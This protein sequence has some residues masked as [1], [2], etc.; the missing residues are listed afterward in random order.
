MKIGYHIG[1]SSAAELLNNIKESRATIES[2]GFE[3]CVQI[4]VS[5][6]RRFGAMMP[7]NKI[8]A[9]RELDIPIVVHGAYIDLPWKPGAARAISNIVKEYQICADIGAR[10]LVV[11]FSRAATV[12]ANAARALQR[13]EQ[14]ILAA[15][16]QTA[17]QTAGLDRGPILFLE[18]NS[19]KPEHCDF[20]HVHQLN[21]FFSNIRALELRIPVGLCIDTAHLWACGVSM[22]TA[23]DVQAWFGTLNVR[24]PLL[25]H[26]NDNKHEL[27]AGR[28]YHS[29]L[30]TNIW[31]DIHSGLMEIMQVAD[32]HGALFIVERH[33]E[34]INNES[35]L[36]LL[37]SLAA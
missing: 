36:A 17:G 6:P 16:G 22:K 24:A 27:A 4:F 19:A 25:L 14:D 20:A 32:R 3:S 29:P 9:I 26:L 34:D 10:G 12:P 18:I 31:A 11:H 8:A 7:E 5:N 23:A 2:Y 1:G 13:I 33:R 30:G 35:E 15:V 21:Q 28:D 37:Q